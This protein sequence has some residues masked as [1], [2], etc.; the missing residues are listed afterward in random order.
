[1]RTQSKLSVYTLHDGTQITTR[2][3]LE[4]RWAIFFNELGLQWKYEP[5]RIGKYLP[6]FSV[7]GFGFVEVKP[8]LPLLISESHEFIQQQA[9][10]DDKIYAFCG[11]RV[12]FCC[13]VLYHH[14]TL[15]APTHSQI[16]SSIAPLIK[17]YDLAYI[18]I[19]MNRA[20]TAKLDHFVSIG[21]V[22]DLNRIA[23]EE[24]ERF[25]EQFK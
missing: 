12:G 11:E 18:G 5:Q 8:S 14:E 3:A 4:A 16:I 22:I 17:S 9:G 21:K 1:M 15:F 20:N 10:F 2:S 23:H 6:D 24:T 7:D 25:K 13:S 19:A